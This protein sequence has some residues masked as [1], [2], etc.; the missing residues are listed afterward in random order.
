MTHATVAK[1]PTAIPSEG[2]TKPRW[3][4][5]YIS[6]PLL[7]CLRCGHKWLPSSTFDIATFTWKRPVKCP[8]CS[9]ALWDKAYAK[10]VTK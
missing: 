7:Q 8:K 1:D 6:I 10:A 3:I 2:E 9:T 4:L 5:R